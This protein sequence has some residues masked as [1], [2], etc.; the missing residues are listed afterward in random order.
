AE[1]GPSTDPGILVGTIAYMSPEQ[2]RAEP[3][4]SAGD[5]F[6]LGIVLYELAAGVH[7]FQ[8]DSA[9]GLL[10]AIVK[11]APVPPTRLNPELPA[12][13]QAL[14]LQMLQKDARLRPSAAE[15]EAG[16]AD[17]A[18]G[19]RKPA[20]GATPPVKRPTVGRQQELADLHACF[21]SACEGRGL[22]LCVAGEPGI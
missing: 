5:I 21:A 11:Q 4:S 10:H 9:V 8:A 6:S 17:L 19:G 7:P 15:V 2:A 3:V 18:R 20:G 16:L 1:P 12:S 13:L 22:V 14:V